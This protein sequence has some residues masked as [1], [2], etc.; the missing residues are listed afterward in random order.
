MD[1]FNSINSYS[2]LDAWIDE[3]VYKYI[4]VKT[5]TQSLQEIVC[6]NGILHDSLIG[7]EHY[8]ELVGKFD[9]TIRNCKIV[10]RKIDIYD[11]MIGEEDIDFDE[12]KKHC[13]E[14]NKLNK[15]Y[16]KKWNKIAP[17]I[18]SAIRTI[19]KTEEENEL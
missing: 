13:E 19:K 6:P 8:H 18:R 12:V 10:L 9:E 5:N 3:Q 7:Y 11:N 2:E 15:I 17:V 14:I 1:D 16:V 4:K